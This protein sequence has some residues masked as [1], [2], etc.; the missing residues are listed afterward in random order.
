MRST[1]SVGCEG[2]WVVC[3]LDHA[4]AATALLIVS[5]G[6]EIAVGPRRS[7]ARL[8]RLIADR[9][10]PV[11]RFDRRGIGD[12][13]GANGGYRSSGP[14]I[15]AA[16]HMSAHWRI[17]RIVAFGN[18]DAATALALLGPQPAPSRWRAPIVA[19]VLANPWLGPR[20]DGLLSAAATGRHYR[21]RLTDPAAWRALLSGQVDLSRLARGVAHVVAPAREEPLA[22]EVAAALLATPMPT[23]IVV[24]ADDATGATFAGAWLTPRFAPL[25]ERVPIHR[26]KTGSHGFTGDT[27]LAELAAILLGALERVDGRMTPS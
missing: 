9:G 12:S 18:C 10:W 11:V 19:R 13:G 23:E 24:S 15:G 17:E 8:A 26:I 5:G 27:D 22:A 14:D 20:H 1:H 25:R 6:N 4:P 3:T 7:M 16:C 2:E 21:G